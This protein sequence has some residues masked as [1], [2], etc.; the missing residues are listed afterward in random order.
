MTRFDA[1][2][3]FFR[4][5]ISFQK[6]RIA[7]SE[8]DGMEVMLYWRTELTGDTIDSLSEDGSKV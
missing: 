6:E 5:D 2:Y 7:I 3:C 1:S 4:D 8:A